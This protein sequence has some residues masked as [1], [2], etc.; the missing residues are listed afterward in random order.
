[1]N[2]SDL[3]FDEVPVGAT[4]IRKNEVQ[5]TIWRKTDED[6]AVYENGDRHW[7]LGRSFFANGERYERDRH[8]LSWPD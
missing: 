2:K 5:D 8:L 4:Y 3:T 6:S 7:M 1:M